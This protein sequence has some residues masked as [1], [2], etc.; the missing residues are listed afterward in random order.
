MLHL[1]IYAYTH[2]LA[3]IW[4]AWLE[5][6]LSE[7]I[8]QLSSL[9]FKMYYFLLEICNNFFS[10]Y[11]FSFQVGFIHWSVANCQ[12]SCFGNEVN[13]ASDCVWIFQ[14]LNPME[15]NC[16][17][18]TNQSTNKSHCLTCSWQ[19]RLLDCGRYRR[20]WQQLDTSFL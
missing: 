19:F 12:F 4:L 13:R 14:G 6:K 9:S 20:T 3:F 5:N 11:S 8:W 7:D 17:Q 15:A 10:C 16:L 1:N 2:K 18:Y